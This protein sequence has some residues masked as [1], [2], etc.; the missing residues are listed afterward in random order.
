MEFTVTP[1][2]ESSRTPGIGENVAF[3]WVLGGI[4]QEQDWQIAIEVDPP[5]LA[6]SSLVL[7]GHGPTQELARFQA[8]RP[9]VGGVSF[10]VNSGEQRA[11]WPIR[12]G[13]EV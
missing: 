6:P 10:V 4:E 7:R 9:G 5:L 13:G 3:A 12:V 8:V 2:T 11:Y 1:M